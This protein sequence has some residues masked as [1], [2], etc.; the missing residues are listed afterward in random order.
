MLPKLAKISFTK[1]TLV[2]SEISSW[3]HRQLHGDTKWIRSLLKCGQTRHSNDNNQSQTGDEAN[4]HLRTSFIEVSAE[5]GIF[6]KDANQRFFNQMISS[7]NILPYLG[8]IDGFVD[9]WLL[10]WA[11]D[12]SLRVFE[13][14]VS[15]FFS[16][17]TV[18]C[19]CS[20]VEK[21][22]FIVYVE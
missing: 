16:T 20:S 3:F 14:V 19:F 15:N 7:Q 4:I 5:V 17:L 2:K 21:Y 6:L 1:V 8:K 12:R 22:S 11:F 9:N 13:D 18:R 10:I